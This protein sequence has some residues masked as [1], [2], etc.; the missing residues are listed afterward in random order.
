MN[1]RIEFESSAKVA[2]RF[3]TAVS[4]HS[5]TLHSK[6]TL[7]FV[8][9]LR[10]RSA[11]LA[12]ALRRG[13]YCYWKKYGTR[14]DFG[15]AWWTP[16]CAP[17]DAYLLE[18]R[19]IEDALGVAAL[20]SLTDHDDIEAPMSLRV[21]EDCREL[22]VSVEWT[23]P[24]CDTFFHLGIHNLCAS[25][26]RS[27]MAEFSGFTRNPQRNRIPELLDF[28]YGDPEAL[29]VFNHPCWDEKGIGKDKHAARVLE[30]LNSYSRSI[31]ALELN[32]LRPWPENRMVLQLAKRFPKPL[33][34]G[35]DR[36]ALEPN[37]MLDL[38][39]ASTFS[40]F[41]E[42][43]RT[44][45]TTVLI[46]NQ[47]R[48]PFAL[49]ILENLEDILQDLPEHGRGWVKWSD[50][51]FFQ[52]DDGSVHNATALFCNHVPTAVQIFVKGI[53][54][55]RRHRIPSKFRAAF[56]RRELAL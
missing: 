25:R 35:G 56:P 30:F 36:H 15:R 16:P 12:T 21:L 49:R 54:L 6:E 48:E 17:H 45:Y 4:L 47:Y 29:I 26:A 2:G 8:N 28:I 44:G 23:V 14:L 20:V 51:V 24:F 34:S 18:R 42:Q 7:A 37:T 1:T 3:R 31:H 13:E 9:R 22:P 11:S 38:T 52:K 5:H 46:R 40:E 10:K 53:G 19:C 41:V 43:V 55:L 50:R 32:G 27:I 39:N 33:I